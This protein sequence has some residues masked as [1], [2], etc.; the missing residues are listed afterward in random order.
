[1]KIKDRQ[2]KI[3]RGGRLLRML[4]AYAEIKPW[5]ETERK[6]ILATVR[7]LNHVGTAAA[8]L[9]ISKSK[10]YTKL[11]FYRSKRSA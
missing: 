11:K 4:R 8:L 9:G 5:S 3:K 6:I 7:K 10:L 1:M 2:S